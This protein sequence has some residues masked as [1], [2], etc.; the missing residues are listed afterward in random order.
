[1]TQQ[2]IK[3]QIR[4]WI[5][6]L[7]FLSASCVGGMAADKFP[8]A[9]EKSSIIEAKTIISDIQVV[10]NGPLEQ[11]ES[12]AY[13]AKRLIRLHPGDQLYEGDVQ[14]SIKA[15]TF[16][17]RFSAIHVD[18]VSEQGGEALVF[19]LTPYVTIEDIVI[20]GEYP[21]FEKDILNQMTMYPGDPYNKDDLSSQNEVIVKRYKREGYVDPKVS[22]K[23][24]LDTDSKNVI[25][26]VDIEKGP[27]YELGSLSFVGNHSISSSSLSLRMAVWRR[28]VVPF[29]GWFS[30]YQLKKDMASLLSYYRSEG[31]ADAELSYSLDYPADSHKVN[32][33]FQIQE[34]KYYSVSFE[35]NKTFW[36]RTLN[37]DVVIATEGNRSNMGI[38]R[39][40]QNIKKRY[41]DAGFLNT[42]LK[43]EKTL[44]PGSP[45]DTQ[46]LRFVI[47]EGQQTIVENVIID[48]NRLLAESEIK[49]Q[50]LTRPPTIF[51]DGSFVPEVLET[52]TFAIDTLY[53][54]NGFLE[55]SVDSEVTFTEDKARADVTLEIKEGPITKV[56]S[57]IIKGLSVLPEK[58]AR[59]VLVQK[60]GDP[61]RKGVLDTE[62]E[63]IASLVSEK[64][65][66]H[67]TVQA[68][69]S[70]SKD[71]TQADIIYEIDEGPLVTLGNIFISGNLL[72]S[73][74]IIR[75]ELEIKPNSPLSLQSLYDGQRRLRD[76][77]IFHGVTYRI[78]G[79]K[80]KEKTVDLF[81]E[82][83]ENKPYYAEMSLGYESDSGIFGGAK[84]G[85]RN[86]FGLNKE[87][88]VYG[89]MS[90]TGHR[91]ET[92]LKEP[93]FMG[94]LTTA[95]VGIFNEELTEFNQ[96]FGTRTTGGSLAFGRD[97]GRH[98]TT[99]LS[100]RL[101]D[102]EQF[103]VGN[104]Q[105]EKDYEENRTI[106]VTT[107]YLRYDSRD[108]F[109]RPTKGFL[110]SLGVD[111]SNGIQG[112]LDDFVRYQFDARYYWTPLERVTFAGMARLGQVI[113]YGNSNLVSDDQ[114]F[115]L[116]GIQSVRGY[117]EN[118]LRYDN[119][120]NSVGG[121][122]AVVGSLEARIDL[123]MNLEL[124]TFFDIGSVQD[125]LVDIG[126]DRFRSSVGLGLRYI[127]PIGPIG[128]LYGHK[129]DRDEGE[130]A[131]M[132]YFSIGYTF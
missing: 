5:L 81:V 12:Y 29:I 55:R 85:N 111:I 2:H 51:H 14:K 39:S 37:K 77:E 23:A 30:K 92:R 61:F 114:L 116:G 102:R 34:G 72:T 122:V 24:Q 126:S 110:A 124:T 9:D 28:S 47:E 119:A 127:T 93:R 7:G 32:V 33:T 71:R 76:M 128:L 79:L 95:S 97:W 69:V 89:K 115:Y 132:V 36:D 99:A 52:D 131:G 48:G 13:I 42:Q 130:S 87:L 88:W 125:T 15:L 40:V 74:K 107:P 31:F 78:F 106:F 18:S 121:K 20:Q 83:Q 59:K 105:K 75:Q 21:L 94:T 109:V 57:I 58:D 101:E 11:R 118:M 68:I 80:E 1:M 38:R 10:I 26:L 90:E 70:Y 46:S 45:T 117:S 86:L 82:V 100:F 104:Q 73:E 129:L 49:E 113:P 120:G 43:T 65:Y 63:A 123:G 50:V 64:G 60:I 16:S 67:V 62:K 25:I 19:T 22:T 91:F 98:I 6:I 54:N 96:S 44:I 17:N 84:L 8:V 103:S 112:E 41:H 66:P 56:H 108:S 35:G 3:K 27:H 4:L 53:M